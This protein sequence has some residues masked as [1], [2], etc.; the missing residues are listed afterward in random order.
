VAEEVV[1]VVDLLAEGS[2]VEADSAADLAAEAFQ[3][4]VLAEAGKK[5]STL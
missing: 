5:T 3:E 4:V 2:A 1:S